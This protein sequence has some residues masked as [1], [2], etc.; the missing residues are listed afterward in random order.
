MGVKGL[1]QFVDHICP[2]VKVWVDLKEMAEQYRCSHPGRSPVVIVD[3]LACLRYWYTSG[4]WVHGGQWREY[5][6]SLKSFVR[7]F[8]ATSIE[9]VFVFDGVIE[10]KKRDEWIKRRLRNNR[11]IATI[12]QYIKATAC[13]PGRDMF[14]IPSG[15]ATFTCFALKSLGLNVMV[16]LKEADYE[17]ASYARLNDGMAILSQDTDFLIYDTV[18]YLSIS[19][20]SL[21]K[22]T[23][24]MYS[25]ENLCHALRLQMMDLPLL[26]CLLG[27]DIVSESVVGRLKSRCLAEYSLGGPN[28]RQRKEMVA[29]VACYISR[30]DHSHSG[31]K[32]VK[33]NLQLHSGE[34]LLE[35]GVE[36][37]L[38]PGQ[39]SPWLPLNRISPATPQCEM[40]LHSDLKILQFAREKHFKAESS[41]VYKILSTGEV[42]CS[43]TLEDDMDPDLPGQ[44]IV[45]RSARQSVYGILLAAE[46]YAQPNSATSCRTIKEWFVYPGN[47]LQQPDLVPALPPELPGGIPDLQTLWLAEGSVVEELRYRTFLAC[48]GIQDYIEEF[49][50]L[51]DPT[52]AAVC[53][54][55]A[56]ITLQ[57]STLSLEDLNAYLAQMLCIQDKSADQLSQ[58]Q[59]PRVDSRAV[60]LASLFIRGL[61][62]LISI[63]SAC[64]FPFKM[65]DLMPW[66]VFDGKLFH[67]KYLQSHS[68]ST[69]EDLLEKND[70]MVHKFQKLKDLIN[71][72][73]AGKNRI[74][75]SQPRP[76]VPGRGM[77][78]FHGRGSHHTSQG[79][80]FSHRPWYQGQHPQPRWTNS[81]Q[82][83]VILSATGGVSFSK[84]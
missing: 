40:P 12:F 45:Y 8:S 52:V 73:C 62:M 39:S 33:R 48:F 42:D 10:E 43:N 77:S 6:E 68:G 81:A 72:V 71:T 84:L 67:T 80:H 75:Q 38:M 74:I 5:L 63:N 17:I 65:V 29:A 1:Q 56:Y 46:S 37:Y 30:V 28:A 60:H 26:A 24:V 58:I 11:E 25:R 35:K 13:Q 23:T 50:H 2:A 59:V 49:Q 44:A 53:C 34:S 18:P 57:V 31:L 69:M 36:C 22:L 20:L 3:T 79:A 61:A 76:L 51:K 9:L 27:N 21:E 47:L 32:E 66:E 4:A 82:R 14:F 83:D 41:M 70:V 19:N 64:G 7:A 55:L 54:L 16:S 15:L 78:D